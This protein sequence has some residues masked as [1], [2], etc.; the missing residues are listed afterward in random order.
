LRYQQHDYRRR[1]QNNAL[2]PSASSHTA[3]SVHSSPRLFSV[4]QQREI[5][6]MTRASAS[7]GAFSVRDSK[8]ASPAVSPL[9]KLQ[10]V[11]HSW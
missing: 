5:I 4:R 1:A 7:R 2:S 8:A 9:L 3:H 10:S 6:S 11:N